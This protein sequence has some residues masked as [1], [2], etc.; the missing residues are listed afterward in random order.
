M[1]PR[2]NQQHHQNR[3]LF[4][5]A[6]REASPIFGHSITDNSN[7]PEIIE[8]NIEMSEEEIEF[9]RRMTSSIER[10]TDLTRRDSFSSISSC[11]QREQF[12]TALTNIKTSI[13]TEKEKTPIMDHKP[14]PSGSNDSDHDF[15]HL[16]APDPFELASYHATA[17]AI[18]PTSAA[19]PTKTQKMS[20]EFPHDKSPEHYQQSYHHEE[21]VDPFAGGHGDRHNVLERNNK[22]EML[23][24]FDSPEPVARPHQ[25]Y[26]SSD[27]NTDPEP[28]NVNF[29]H[30][31]TERK[32]D[33]P[34]FHA[35]PRLDSPELLG[36]HK[37]DAHSD[38][39]VDPESPFGVPNVNFHHFQTE[40]K[41]ESPQHHF[42]EHKIESSQ[43]PDEPKHAREHEVDHVSSPA[44]HS[45]A[46]EENRRHIEENI[47]AAVNDTH[48]EVDAILERLHTPDPAEVAVPPVPE[49]D[50]SPS[51]DSGRD[52]LGHLAGET[53]SEHEI[54]MPTS[55]STHGMR[56]NSPNEDT[57]D[58]HGP[59]TIPTHAERDDS[60][61]KEKVPSAPSNAEDDY[62]PVSE[63]SNFNQIPARPPTPPKDLNDDDYNPA[64]IDLGPAPVHHYEKSPDDTTSLKP[65]LKH[66][67]DVEPWLTRNHVDSRILDIIYWRDPKKSGIALGAIFVLLFLVAKFSFILIGTYS[68]LLILICTLGFRI[69]K[70]A[71]AKFKKTED[72][73]PFQP[74]LE[75]ELDVPQ[76]KIHAQVDVLVENV[77]NIAL[78][79]RRLFFVESVVDSVKFFF[80]LYSLTYIGSWFSG[81]ALIILFVIGVFTVP[82]VYEMNKEPIDNYLHLA[83]ENVDKLHQTVGEKVPFLN[84]SATVPPVTKKEE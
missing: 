46:D 16:E 23:V 8:P 51:G 70:L 66:H 59:L 84:T 60:L 4:R 1:E 33:S 41:V 53:F 62:E 54:N 24:D 32:A 45:P 3:R 79:L 35:E 52:T 30:F 49:D 38:F 26:I 73:N 40:H 57:F 36:E 68:A 44:R 67:S 25:N 82:K 39:N 17:A 19:T 37:H 76:E 18:T 64:A 80:L 13:L 83:K 11:G 77:R 50:I 27:I 29:H 15:E 5:R 21:P 9:A 22:E 48:D 42:D 47:E 6:F 14:Q 81:F 56:E 78:Q 72:K 7:D 58:R 55:D 71:E 28:P 69:F 43:F 10:L 63:S 12:Q 65:I 31:Q 74:M 75:K 61:A 34:E 20:H 2:Q